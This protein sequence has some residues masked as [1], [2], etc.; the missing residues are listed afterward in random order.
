MAPPTMP[1]V[2]MAANGA[3]GPAISNPGMA[4]AA[5]PPAAAA[6]AAIAPPVAAAPPA[7]AA[8][9]AAPA[10]K[11]GMRLGHMLMS[12]EYAAALTPPSP[13]PDLSPMSKPGLAHS[14]MEDVNMASVEIGAF[15]TK[16][17]SMTNS[18]MWHMAEGTCLLSCKV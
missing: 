7:A 13:A 11:C 14:G 5:E 10:I 1:A 18:R 2:T 4:T 12:P 3:I 17:S 6:P 9:P 16:T 8:V 15:A